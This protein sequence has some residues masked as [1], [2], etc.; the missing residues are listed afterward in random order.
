PGTRSRGRCT[1]ERRRAGATAG[2]AASPRRGAAR[3]R[4]SRAAD[5]GRS[6]RRRVRGRG[7]ARPGLLPPRGVAGTRESSR[8]WSVTSAEQR[9][10]R[11]DRLD[12]RTQ[13]LEGRR[14]REALAKVLEWLI[15]RE[16]RPDRRD[17]EEDAAR[18]A[19]IDR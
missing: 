14:Q 13:V 15:G 11:Q 16:S 5:R 2:P 10:R 9:Q 18:L 8:R 7:R 4:G 12:L 3:G 6:R 1:S 19:E 17:L